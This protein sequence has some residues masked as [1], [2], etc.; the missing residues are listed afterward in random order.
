MEVLNGKQA[1]IL[2]IDELPRFVHLLFLEIV[3]NF[4]PLYVITFPCWNCVFQKILVSESAL[5]N[6]EI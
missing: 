1:S 5:K 2:K 3:L 4:L 6:T